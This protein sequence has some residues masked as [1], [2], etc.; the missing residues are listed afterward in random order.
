MR[1]LLLTLILLSCSCVSKQARINQSTAA[2]NI[3]EAAL[4]LEQGAS[5]VL[6]LPRIKSQAILIIKT[7]GD[8]YNGN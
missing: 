2:A 4:A 5:S 6:I 8:T 3:Y 1:I 7:N